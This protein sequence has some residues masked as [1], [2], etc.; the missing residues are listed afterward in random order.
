MHYNDKLKKP[1]SLE[2]F[3]THYNRFLNNNVDKK[4]AGLIKTMNEYKI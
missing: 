1:E 4:Y 2:S 3:D